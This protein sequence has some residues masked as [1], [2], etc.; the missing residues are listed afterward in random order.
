VY[1]ECGRT[2]ALVLERGE[3]ADSA[4]IIDE[5]THY[6]STK[7]SLDHITFGGSGEPTLNTGT[8]RIVRFLKESYPQYKCA[9]LTN[10]TLL[11]LPQVRE[12]VLPFDIVLPSLDAVSDAV[13]AKVNRPHGK[14]ENNAV[15]K[16]LIE[17]RKSYK[18]LVWLEV[19]IV[20]GINDT[21][22]ELALFKKAITE[23]NPDRVQLNS[24]DRPGTCGWVRPASMEKLQEIAGFFSPLPVEIISRQAKN[25]P[26]P[27]AAERA[28]DSILAMVARRPSTIEEIATLAGLTINEA[29]R[30][31]SALVSSHRIEKQVT[32][33]R[34]FYRMV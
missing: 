18:G 26:L 10:G 11:Y 31:L 33:N 24:L 4:K 19:F 16:G 9:L 7:P 34:S 27:Q 23:I 17:F 20:P 12:E 3:Y 1:C 32:G 13:F 14:L 30:I 21:P 5:L 6:L 29:D 22:E 28:S 25:S 15:I 8:G 2:T